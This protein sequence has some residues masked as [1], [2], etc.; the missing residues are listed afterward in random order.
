MKTRI[1]ELI[2]NGEVDR[3]GLRFYITGAVLLQLLSLRCAHCHAACVDELIGNGEVD[4][5]GLRL[6]ITGT[7]F[8]QLLCYAVLCCASRQS[9]HPWRFV[10]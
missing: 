1:G 10:T 8:L 5:E 3:E 6:Y 2:A 9:A 7:G 4:Q